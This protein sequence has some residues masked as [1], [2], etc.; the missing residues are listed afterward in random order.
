LS[1]LTTPA[2]SCRSDS[3]IEIASPRIRLIQRPL[4]RYNLASSL[5][6][7]KRGLCPRCVM[8]QRF[9]ARG[10]RRFVYQTVCFRTLTKNH[11]FRQVFHSVF[12]CPVDCERKILGVLTPKTRTQKHA[13]FMPRFSL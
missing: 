4:P 9:C 5:I 2:G 3:L 10:S 11:S 1:E 12:F 8:S 7:Q 13:R 6:F